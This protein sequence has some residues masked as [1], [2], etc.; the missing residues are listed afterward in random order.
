MAI[1]LL[2]SNINPFTNIKKAISEIEKLSGVSITA[3]SSLYETEPVGFK[4]QPMF[5]NCCLEV[6][7]LLSPKEL[8]YQTQG[9][10]EAMGRTR[11]I[12]WGPRVI[13][14]DILLYGEEVISDKD[15]TIPHPELHHRLFAL[16]PL[17]EIAPNILH[18]I[19]KVS[20]KELISRKF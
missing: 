5:I 17:A 11:K 16:I 19:L 4:P 3:K 20:I 2:G 10:E 1:L 6:S 9:I 13:D 15:L 18:P 14:I 12:K 8:L 7:T